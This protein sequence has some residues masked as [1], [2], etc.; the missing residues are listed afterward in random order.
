MSVPLQI[1]R[2]HITHLSINRCGG[3]DICGARVDLDGLVHECRGGGEDWAHVGDVVQ[4]RLK[5][6]EE[7]ESGVGIE[8]SFSASKGAFYVCSES[9]EHSQERIRETMEMPKIA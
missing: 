6:R 5:R 9:Q 4:R 8:Q 3:S 2:M 1:S 7:V